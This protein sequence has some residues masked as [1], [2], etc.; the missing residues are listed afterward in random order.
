MDMA[1]HLIAELKGEEMAKMIQLR[2]EYD[3]QPPFDAGSPSKAGEEIEAKT[4]AL[5]KSVV[6][7]LSPPL[8][9]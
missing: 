2:T 1:L 4:I 9:V 5:A 7:N 3:P 6:A 8:A